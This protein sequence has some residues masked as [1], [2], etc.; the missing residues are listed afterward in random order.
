L[1]VE[2]WPTQQSANDIVMKMRVS[3]LLWLC[4]AAYVPAAALDISPWF[5][6]AP[7]LPP[8]QGE[9]IRVATVDELLTAVERAESGW[10]ILLADGHYKVPRV[11]VL[12]QNHQ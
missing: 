7:V 9:V 5:P 10:T 3:L 12:Q 8:P 2:S 4:A 6:T 1:E 11:I